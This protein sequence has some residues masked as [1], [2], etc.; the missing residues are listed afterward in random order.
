MQPS[1]PRTTGTS[2][3][4][5]PGPRWSAV[6][7]AVVGA[8]GGAVRRPVVGAA[9]ACGRNGRTV[10]AVADVT[11]GAG[12]EPTGFAVVGA[13]VG[14][15]A[16]PP[17]LGLRVPPPSLVRAAPTDACGAGA[18][19][20]PPRGRRLGR[21][22]RHVRSTGTSATTGASGGS[23]STGAASIAAWDAWTMTSGVDPMTIVVSVNPPA[24]QAV[25]RTAGCHWATRRDQALWPSMF[26]SMV[27][28]RRCVRT[29]L[30]P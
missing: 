24:T 18:A 1:R 6:G 26:V 4:P 30:G 7:A 5:P 10:R 20:R 28:T 23:V 9:V 27:G 29:G 12:R 17:A 8:G 14:A 16:G 3:P 19:A 13:T 15:G 2:A 11:T 22:G 25:T 21:I